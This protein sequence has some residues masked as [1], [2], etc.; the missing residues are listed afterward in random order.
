M[1]CRLSAVIYSF[2][3]FTA[4]MWVAFLVLGLKS[5]H[6]FNAL[7]AALVA[8]ERAKPFLFNNRL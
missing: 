8:G 5:S 3:T 4:Q 1:F 7:Q 6:D 2:F